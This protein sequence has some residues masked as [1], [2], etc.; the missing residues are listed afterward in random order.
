MGLPLKAQALG[1]F[2]VQWHG[3]FL[4][5]HDENNDIGRLDGDL[6]L[7]H[8]GADDHVVGFFAAQ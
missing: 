1:H 7:F 3:A 5:V 2:A 8:R 6:D 4:D